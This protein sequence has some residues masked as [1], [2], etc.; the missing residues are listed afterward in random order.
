[1]NRRRFVH[2]FGA[3]G[4]SAASYSRILGANDRLGLALIGAGRRGTQVAAAFLAGDQVDL[5]CVCDVYDAH[6]Q[7]AAAVLTKTG[8]APKQVSKHEESLGFKDVDVVLIAAPDHL[9]V[10]LAEAALAAG[11]HV[12]L[13]KPTLHRWE[14]RT[15]LKAAAEKSNRVLQCGMQQR[16]GSHYLRAKEDIFNPDTVNALIQYRN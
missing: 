12:Y 8:S 7:K 9:H 14:E 4:I 15:R 10:T 6:C 1:M 5:R 3:I 11:K 13:E 16:S 2:T